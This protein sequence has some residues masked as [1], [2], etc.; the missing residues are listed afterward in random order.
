MKEDHTRVEVEKYCLENGKDS[1]D[2]EV[3]VAGAG[4]TLYPAKL[5]ASGAVCRDEN[6]HPLYVEDLPVAHWINR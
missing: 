4:F 1:A 3:P 6:G 5:D 2:G